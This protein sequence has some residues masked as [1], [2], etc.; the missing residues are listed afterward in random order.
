MRALSQ[1][2]EVLRTVPGVGPVTAITLLALLPELGQL[3][4]KQIASLCGV[5][6]YARQSGE[7]CGYR[8]TF[9][10]RRNLRPVLFMA[11]MGAKRKKQSE[12]SSFCERLEKKGKKPMVALVAIMRKIIVISNARVREKFF[13]KHS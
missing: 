3:N 2:R 6:P 8:R 5:A 11:A 7:K 12:L 4:R 13:Q 9:G 10:G 1:K